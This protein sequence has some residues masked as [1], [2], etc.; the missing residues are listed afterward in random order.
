MDANED[1][2]VASGLAQTRVACRLAVAVEGDDALGSHFV[3][4]TIAENVTRAGAFVVTRRSLKSG[5]LLALHDSED[6]DSRLCY[7]QVVW[8]RPA[9]EVPPGVGVKIVNNNGRWI[10]YLVAHSMQTLEDDPTF[11]E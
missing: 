7:V 6:Y 3:E 4:T 8:V 5:T 1:N 10:E 2:E 9:G 11:V